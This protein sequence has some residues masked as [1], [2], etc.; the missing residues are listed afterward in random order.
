M[1]TLKVNIPLGILKKYFYRFDKN[2]NIEKILLTNYSFYINK[3]KNTIKDTTDI[4]IKKN[5]ESDNM[6]PTHNDISIFYK[7]NEY[8]KYIVTIYHFISKSV[9]NKL[10]DLDFENIYFNKILDDDLNV[11]FTVEYKE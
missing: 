8:M 2:I 5:F 9:M 7:P 3:N 10:E 11:E 6:K 4:I 1:K